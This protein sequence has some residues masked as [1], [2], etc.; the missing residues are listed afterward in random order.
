VL[1]GGRP[2]QES[3][4]GEDDRRRSRDCEVQRQECGER[5][6]AGR[7]HQNPD[8]EGSKPHANP[9]PVYVCGC[10]PNRARTAAE[11]RPGMGKTAQE[12]ATFYPMKEG[13]RVFARPRREEQR[14]EATGSTMKPRGGGTRGFSRMKCLASSELDWPVRARKTSWGK[15]GRF[16][17]SRLL[18]PSTRSGWSWPRSAGSRAGPGCG[19]SASPSAPCSARSPPNRRSRCG[20]ARAR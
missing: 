15:R 8:S 20:P 12:R 19:C 14:E 17:P 9:S 5:K 2:M 3:Q 10:T 7:R 13:M 1:P 6:S 18:H 16:V 4:N 11:P